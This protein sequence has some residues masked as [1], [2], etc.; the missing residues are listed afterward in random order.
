MTTPQAPASQ[1]N[2]FLNLLFNVILPVIILT[3]FSDDS[4][5]G[6]VLGLIVA[7]SFPIGFGLWEIKKSGKLNFFSVVGII[8]VLLTGGIGLLQLDPKYIAIKEAMVPGVI[9]V[10]VL[11]SNHTRFPLIKTLLENMPLLNLPKLWQHLA[12][13]QQEQA[14][15]QVLQQGNRIVAAAFFLSSTLNYGLARYLVVSPAGTPAYNEEIGQM[16]ALS[17]PVIALPT[18][19]I[20]MAALWFVLSRI[21]KLTGQPLDD[22]LLAQD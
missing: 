8:S 1:T 6:P 14:F 2:T 12:D 16:T 22:F 17:F 20:L 15:V 3:K 11:F 13:R 4:S 19:I 9:G 7:L 21:P 18:T 5:L 10:L